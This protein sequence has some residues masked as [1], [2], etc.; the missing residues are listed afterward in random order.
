M[1]LS[2]TAKSLIIN[3]VIYALVLNIGYIVLKDFFSYQYN[4]TFIYGIVLGSLF[5]IIK[6][7]LLEQ[8]INKAVT[9]DEKSA[10]GYMRSM[11]TLRYFLTGGVLLLSATNSSI[12][13]FG[14]IFGIISLQFA[15]YLNKI[16]KI[17]FNNHKP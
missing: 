11:Y 13:L 16:P 2:K 3:I 17:K 4:V 12:D 9:F 6:V 14:T 5:S 7:V 1:K 10:Q 15:V 8:T